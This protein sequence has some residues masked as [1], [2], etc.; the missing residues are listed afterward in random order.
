IVLQRETTHERSVQ[1]FLLVAKARIDCE[2]V[3]RMPR[4]LNE[5]VGVLLCRRS[6]NVEVGTNDTVDLPKHRI[7]KNVDLR[8][9]S[10]RPAVRCHEGRT[11]AV[12]ELAPVNVVVLDAV[13][14]LMSAEDV[15]RL[16]GPL[17]AEA[18]IFT[19]V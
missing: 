5:K 1:R 7:R 16:R 11:G 17:V 8:S 9:C 10:R 19:L 15:R 13:L 18:P 3:R 14:D 4:I 2:S 12:V 6:L